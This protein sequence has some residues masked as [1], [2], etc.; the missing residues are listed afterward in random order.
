M[1]LKDATSLE[2]EREESEF[3]TSVE[4][5]RIPKAKAISSREEYVKHV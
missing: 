1:D 5:D 2:K 3:L 4:T